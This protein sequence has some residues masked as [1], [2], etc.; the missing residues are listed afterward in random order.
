MSGDR[1]KISDQE[2]P[3]A[4]LATNGTVIDREEHYPFG[5]SSLRTFSK[6]RYR[7]VGKE[8]DLES[9]FVSSHKESIKPLR[10]TRALI[11]THE[12]N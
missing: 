3:S 2:A 7:Y 9:G 8:K 4:R 12:V 11:P 1:Y 10:Y 6:K 5:D